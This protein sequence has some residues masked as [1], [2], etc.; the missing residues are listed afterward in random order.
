MTWRNLACIIPI[1]HT[2]LHYKY[3]NS[4]N[5]LWASVY[6]LQWVIF[7]WI[8]IEKHLL[9]L[10][11]CAP[12]FFLCLWI[13]LYHILIL[14]IGLLN[15]FY[16]YCPDWLISQYVSYIKQFLLFPAFRSIF[17]YLFKLFLSY[18]FPSW[19]LLWRMKQ[20]Y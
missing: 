17:L 6:V 7:S 2:Y 8:E 14:Y 11:I 18:I 3:V 4:T 15:A 9:I 13:A 5:I 20:R 16:H 19:S 1:T 10:I 12:W